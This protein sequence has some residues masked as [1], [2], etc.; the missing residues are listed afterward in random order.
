MTDDRHAL[1]IGVNDYEWRPFPPLEACVNDVI[2]LEQRLSMNEALAGGVA[3]KNFACE[4]LRS[5]LKKVG[6]TEVRQRIKALF[7]REDG[8]LLFYFSGHAGRE[9]ADSYLIVTDSDEGA[10]GFPM[11]ELLTLAIKSKAASK[12]IILDCCFAGAAGNPPMFDEEMALLGSGITILSATS[13]RDSAMEVNGHGVFT[14][15]LLGGLDGGA[16]NVR[17][18]ISAAALYGYAEGALGAL[19]QR[20]YYKSH[21]Q[22]L[23]PVRRCKPAVEDSLLAELPVLFL[24]PDARHEMT[25]V[26]ELTNPY[27]D[28][29]KVAIFNKLKIL[30]NAGLVVPDGADDL[31]WCA[32]NNQG[33]KL[34]GLGRYY[35]NLASRKQF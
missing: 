29:E 34:T 20:P 21:T 4:V 16:A 27:R 8:D 18:H 25:A 3:T 12:L 31:Y 35:W 17:G 2:A 9:D 28:L 6:R 19:D 32:I 1:L 11:S 33:A 26:Y 22:S 14:E 13:A 23:A 30:R 15:L 5:D 7:A 10:P 24:R